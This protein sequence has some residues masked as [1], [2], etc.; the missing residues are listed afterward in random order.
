MKA[1]TKLTHFYSNKFT[2]I[3][4][5]YLY[6]YI[7]VIKYFF[8]SIPCSLTHTGLYSRKWC[9]S[10]DSQ[11]YLLCI[12][13]AQRPLALPDHL[14]VQMDQ[15]DLQAPGNLVDP[16]DLGD[17]ADQEHPVKKSILNYVFHRNLI[18]GIVAFIFYLFT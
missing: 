8:F 7:N 2:K 15:Q 10:K 11:R 4:I 13:W 17:R 5:F 18:V 9:C 3:Y 12:L 16:E 6:I 14:S 1:L